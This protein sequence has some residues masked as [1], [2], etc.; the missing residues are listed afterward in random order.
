APALGRHRLSALRPDHVQ[1]L[2]AS[3]LASGLSPRTVHHCHAV[4]HRALE[5]AV[6]WGHLPVNVCDRLDPPRV[7]RREIVPPTPAELGRLL[8]AAEAHEDALR[9]LW[10]TAIYSGCRLGELLGLRWEDIDF[11]RGALT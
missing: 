9:A 3:K 4:L 7:P 2:Y 6:R 10:T 11:G 5:Q 1:Q 8:E